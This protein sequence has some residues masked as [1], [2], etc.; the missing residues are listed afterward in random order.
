[1]RFSAVKEIMKIAPTER[2]KKLRKYYLENSPLSVNRE[3]Y[4]WHCHR[5]LLLYQ[6]GYEAAAY[7][8]DT[9]RIRRSM[10]EKH[11]LENTKPIIIDGELLVGQPDLT[12]FSEEEQVRFKAAEKSFYE[13]T[14]R[15]RGRADHLAM[16]YQLLLDEGIEGII[17]ILDEKIA[18]LDPYD[19]SLTEKYEYYYCCKTELLGLAKLC[20]NYSAEALKM[21]E[22]AEG[23]KKAELL[24]LYEVLKQVPLKP[25]RTFREA[26]QSIQTYTWSLY[27]LYSFGKPDLYL[28]PYYRRDIEKGVMTKEQAQELIDCF[29]LLSVPNMS[30]WASEGLMLGGRDKD[31]KLVENELTWHFLCAIDHTR[32][33]DPNVGFCVT[34]ETDRELLLTVAELIRSGAGQPSVWNSDAVTRSMLKN[35]YDSEAANMFTLSTCVEVTPIGSSGVS[36]TS[37][38]INLL[39]ILLESLD[40]CDDSSSFED[41]FEAFEK[42]FK[43][44]ANKVMLQENL[45]QIERGR[46]ST[47]PMRTSILIHDCIGRGMS[48]D[49]GGAKYNALEPDILGMQNVSESLNCIY[50][51]VFEEKKISLGEYKAALKADFEGEYT[52]LRAYI[53]NKISHFGNNEEVSDNMQKRVAD[54][55]LDTFRGRTTVRGAAVIPG[56]FSYRD[57]VAHGKNTP[58]SPDGRKAGMPLNDGSCPVQGYDRQGPT[59]SLSSTTFWEPA[60]FL[61]GTTVNLKLGQNVSA[62]NIV[63]LIESYLET[64]GAQLQFNVVDTD[65]LLDAQKNPDGY[66]NLLVRIGGYS[67]FFVKLPEDLQNEVISRTEGNV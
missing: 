67:D 18:E 19:G 11:L 36:I 16:D 29:F 14:P 26:L 41:I 64:E 62:E 39:K 51:L 34:K 46:N 50:R 7:E 24:E 55:V 38:Y 12:D 59:A 66:K 40:K 4:S 3:L 48:H 27:G 32:L 42:D 2:V 33:P 53:V 56:A 43:T 54:M 31:G 57:H 13:I 6:E 21:A 35:G 17:R 28:L 20:E 25:A 65:T 1:M 10:A 61:G 45:W 60:R 63:A 23:E 30:A 58:A 9:L 47:D 5:S 15:K 22:A 49:C 52:S 37:P 8:A 44:Y